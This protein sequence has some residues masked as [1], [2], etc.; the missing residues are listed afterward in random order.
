M[1]PK[2]SSKNGFV[3]IITV[4]SCMRCQKVFCLTKMF[5]FNTKFLQN[6][7]IKFGY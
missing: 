7:W 3:S 5:V 6:A 1:E 2:K 4:V